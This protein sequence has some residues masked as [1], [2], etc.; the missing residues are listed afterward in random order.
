MEKEKIC[1]KKNAFLN[2]KI[3]RILKISAVLCTL[4]NNAKSGF[5]YE[6]NSLFNSRAPPIN[7]KKI[8]N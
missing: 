2:L 7:L 6:Q 5:F 4:K 3:H 1:Y 8:S